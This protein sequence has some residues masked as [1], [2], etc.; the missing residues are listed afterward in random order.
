MVVQYQQ[1][2][3]LDDGHTQ[4]TTRV[5]FSSNAR[6]VATAGL[7]GRLCIWDME[8]GE[9]KYVFLGSSPVLSLAWIPGG[10]DLVVCSLADGNIA[11]INI[12]GE[13]IEANGFFAHEQPVEYL[14]LRGEY[15]ASGACQDVCVWRWDQA[16]SKY[17]L[18]HAVGHPPMTSHNEWQEILVTSV[19]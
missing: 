17:I 5:A 18:D 14:A 8:M 4:G 9:L 3:L 6:F 19:Q 12:R 11:C 10:D 1:F 15:L 16:D 2:H 13:F 7:D